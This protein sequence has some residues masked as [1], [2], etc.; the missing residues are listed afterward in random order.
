MRLAMLALAAGLAIASPCVAQAAFE[1]PSVRFGDD[2]DTLLAALT[3]LCTTLRLRPIDPPFLP[4]VT[5][6][7]VQ[8]DCDGYPFLGAPRWAEFVIGDGRLQMIWIMV[9]P[10]DQSRIVE[11]MTRRHGA[12][13]RTNDLYIAFEG[14]RT[15]WRHRPAEVLFYAPELDG[16]V[17][18]WFAGD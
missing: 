1:T 18:R 5:T 4:R 2:P 7:Q 17:S 12:P 10:E 9:R 8:I 15:A 6:K 16:W 13:T 11:A 3:P 14:G